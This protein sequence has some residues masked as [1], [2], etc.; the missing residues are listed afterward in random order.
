MFKDVPLR[1]VVTFH[2]DA[3]SREALEAAVRYVMVYM[4]DGMTGYVCGSHLCICRPKVEWDGGS[5]LVVRSCVKRTA[6]AVAK[7]LVKAYSQ[8]GG[9]TIRIVRCEK[10]QT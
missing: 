9:R 10:H 2:V 4:A 6:Y 5:Q 3:D 8:H 1:Y 7:L